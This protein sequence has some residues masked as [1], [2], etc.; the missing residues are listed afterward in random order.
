MILTSIHHNIR[1]SHETHPTHLIR[2]KRSDETSYFV[3]RSESMHE[4]DTAI[5]LSLERERRKKKG[6]MIA[7]TGRQGCASPIL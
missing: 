5:S 1:P 7:L 6:L 4:K 2:Q 3:G